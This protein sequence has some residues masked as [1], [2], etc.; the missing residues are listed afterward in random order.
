LQ[1]TRKQAAELEQQKKA[2]VDKLNALIAGLSFDW[3]VT[4]K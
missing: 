2:A 4:A 3:D 1:T